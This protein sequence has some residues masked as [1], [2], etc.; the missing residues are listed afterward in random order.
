MSF[1]DRKKQVESFLSFSADIGI[2]Y[3]ICRFFG[4]IFGGIFELLK[5]PIV[6]IRWGNIMIGEWLT[7]WLHYIR[8]VKL[9]K[10]IGVQ[11]PQCGCWV[12]MDAPC[13]ICGTDVSV[14]Q[15]PMGYFNYEKEDANH[16]SRFG[17]PYYELVHDLLKRN[18]EHLAYKKINKPAIDPSYLYTEDC[19]VFNYIRKLECRFKNFC[20][21]KTDAPMFNDSVDFRFTSIQG[22]ANYLPAFADTLFA[23]AHERDLLLYVYQYLFVWKPAHPND[24]DW[25]KNSDLYT[26]QFSIQHTHYQE[27]DREKYQKVRCPVCGGFSNPQDAHNAEQERTCS[28]CGHNFHYSRTIENKFKTKKIG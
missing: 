2:A 1:E 20:W 26:D 15:V 11:C 4:M 10:A 28:S 19:K 12:S 14:K 16:W 7:S 3:L 27:K 22:Y 8:A 13:P 18:A 17:K 9:F 5:D 23:N 6:S 21:S 24:R 25:Q